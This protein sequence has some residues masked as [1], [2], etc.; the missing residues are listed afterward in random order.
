[1]REVASATARKRLNNVISIKGA[2]GFA[3][4]LGGNLACVNRHEPIILNFDYGF[5]VK[6]L[7][8]SDFKDVSGGVG[9]GGDDPSEVDS[10]GDELVFI[11]KGHFVRSCDGYLEFG[12]IMGF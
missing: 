2:N 3:R 7:L 10:V 8:S 5:S 9:I 12:E 11:F 6:S 1:M 4:S